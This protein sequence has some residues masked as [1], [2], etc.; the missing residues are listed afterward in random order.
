MSPDPRVAES[1]VCAD[2]VL[3]AFEQY[4]AYVTIRFRLSRFGTEKSQNLS[5]AKIRIAQNC[6]RALTAVSPRHN[7]CRRPEQQLTW[8]CRPNR[9]VEKYSN[10]R[11]YLLK[12]QRTVSGYRRLGSSKHAIDQ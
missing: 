2:P 1:G 8:R 7:V 3:S 6:C 12:S 11:N 5:H 10:A 9:R 4:W